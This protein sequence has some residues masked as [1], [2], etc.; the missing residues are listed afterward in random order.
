MDEPKDIYV[1]RNNYNYALNEDFD[2]LDELAEELKKKKYP[3][4][5]HLEKET[6][7]DENTE[8]K[9]DKQE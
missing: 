1:Q 5:Q 3:G 8:I 9:T 4:D 7:D 6:P 2:Y